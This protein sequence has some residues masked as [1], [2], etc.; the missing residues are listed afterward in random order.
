MACGGGGSHSNTIATAG[1]N[2]QAISVNSGPDGNYANGAFTS[3]TVCVPGNSTCQTI[4][5][6]L[7]DTGSAGLRPLSSALTI[8][9]PQQKASD[10]DPVVECLPFVNGCTWGPVETADLQIS[11]EK[12]SSLPI[13]VLSDSDFRV[14][15]A[16]ASNG[17]SED[18]LTALGANGILDVGTFAQD[19]G[20]GCAL[21]GPS[22][23]GLYYECP[24]SGCVLTAESLALQVQNPVTLFATDNNG[25]IV[26]LPAVG[27]PETSVSGSLIFGIGTQ[28]NNGLNGA[29]VYTV[30]ANGNFITTYKGQSYNTSFID[31]G[32]NAIFFLNSGTTGTPFFPDAKFYYC[33]STTVNLS[34][35]NQ[36]TNGASG[37]VNFSVANADTL[38]RNNPGASVFGACHYSSDVTCLR[39]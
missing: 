10:G 16:C 12:A 36:G 22:N 1:G 29:T 19:C 32:S 5:G 17:P 3:V 30:D 8:S 18:T 35:I 7:V 37:T 4:S 25:V 23:P 26:E 11:G 39:P 6:M 34:A 28:S 20:G 31:S 33:P 27:A 9:L 15:T 38:F 24:T 21:P 2:V 13:Q 14:T